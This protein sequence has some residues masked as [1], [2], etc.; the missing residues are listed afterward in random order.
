M[1]IAPQDLHRLLHAEHDDAF[2]FL[3][4]HQV[5]QHLVVRAFRPDAKALSVVDRRNPERRFSA[6]RI[7]EEGVFEAQ[8]EDTRERFDYLLEIT[9]WSGETFRI[10][11]AF[12]YG[13]VL[14]ELD[15]HLYC[16]GNHYEIYK[17]L[18]AHL[19][20]INGHKGATFAVWA[21]NAQ[22]VSVVSDFNGWDGRVHPMRKRRESGIWEI[23]IPALTRA[24]ITNTKFG[25]ALARSC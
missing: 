6:E 16:E 14:G 13:P 7:A 21:P 9:N 5:D 19:A 10:S 1:T 23:F 17:K 18:G 12:S 3:G 24:L 15:M 22:R 11:D 20:E 25:T 2:S 4:M 8:I